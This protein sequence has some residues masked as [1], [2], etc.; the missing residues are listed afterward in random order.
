MEDKHLLASDELYQYIRVE[1][2]VEDELLRELREQTEQMAERAMQISPDQGALMHVFVKVMGA[3]NAIEVGTFTG[4]SS[5]CIARAL[6]ADGRL[7]C[8]DVSEAWTGVA[9]QYW[10]KA[11]VDGRIELHLRSAVETLDELIEQGEEGAFDFAFIDAD[12]V[13]YDAYYERCLKLLR[14]GGVIMLDNCLRDGKVIET[15]AD[16]DVDTKAIVAMNKKVHEDDRVEAVLLSVADGLYLV[17][18]K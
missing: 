11:G 5:I 10:K 9:K 1:N 14:P 15:V 17:R 6:P 13:S 12:K 3:Q 18:K 2:T 7:V 8:C 4:Y 16:D